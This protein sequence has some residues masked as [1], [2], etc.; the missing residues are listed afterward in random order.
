MRIRLNQKALNRSLLT[1]QTNRRVSRRE[2]FAGGAA[3]VASLSPGVQA[4]VVA[5]A[6]GPITVKVMRRGKNAKAIISSASGANWTV[7]TALFAGSPALTVES[8]P[9]STTVKLTGARYPGTRVAL[10]FEAEIPNVSTGKISFHFFECGD[11]SASFKVAVRADGLLNGT[12]RATGSIDKKTLDG[13][14]HDLHPGGSVTSLA[15]GTIAFSASG[16]LK[17]VADMELV[18][19]TA[20]P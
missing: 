10:N 4:A 14:F 12:S 16:M 19:G 2:L 7:D 18:T 3:A 20:P 9:K 13:L 5:L 17:A 6:H 15:K 11:G 8:G 1:E